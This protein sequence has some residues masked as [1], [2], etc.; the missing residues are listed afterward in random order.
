MSDYPPS[1][2]HDLSREIRNLVREAAEIMEDPQAAYQMALGVIATILEPVPVQ[3]RRIIGYHLIDRAI[4]RLAPTRRKLPITQER[5]GA[6]ATHPRRQQE[7]GAR[8]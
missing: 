6:H 8:A 7:N 5:S 1:A 3:H 4:A 2:E